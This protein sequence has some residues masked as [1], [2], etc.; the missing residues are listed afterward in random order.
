MEIAKMSLCKVTEYEVSN[1]E[2]DTKSVPTA[3]KKGLKIFLP[4]K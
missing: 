1:G 4:I 3:A 2:N